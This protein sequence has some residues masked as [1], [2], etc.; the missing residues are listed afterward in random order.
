[1]IAVTQCNLKKNC[2]CLIKINTCLVKSFGTQC[3][4]LSFLCVFDMVSLLQCCCAGTEQSCS[5][6]APLRCLL[7]RHRASLP[8]LCGGTRISPSGRSLPHGG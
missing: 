8:L 4:H 7:A 5:L 3:S 6:L 1:M 2:R